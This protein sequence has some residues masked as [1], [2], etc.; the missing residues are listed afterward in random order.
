LNI[1]KPGHP[2]RLEVAADLT[3]VGS[4]MEKESLTLEAWQA[5][6]DERPEAAN[7]NCILPGRD[8]SLAESSETA[9]L[10]KKFGDVLPVK[11]SS[12]TR[13]TEAEAHK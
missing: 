11:N 1:Y 6:A 4:V 3:C 9:W 12:N 2:Q 10:R 5:M 8:R 13:D 7:L